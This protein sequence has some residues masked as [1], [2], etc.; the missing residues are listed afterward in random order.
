MSLGQFLEVVLVVRALL[1]V[2]EEGVFRVAL[3][4]TG[5]FIA[6]FLLCLLWTSPWFSLSSFMIGGMERLEVSKIALFGV[7][8]C[9][10]HLIYLSLNLLFMLYQPPNNKV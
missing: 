7:V 10:F 4:R 8:V 6:S 5:G 3:R 1:A 2:F 9:F